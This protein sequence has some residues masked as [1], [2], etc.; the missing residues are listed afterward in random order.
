MQGFILIKFS[1]FINYYS[2]NSDIGPIQIQQAIPIS[3]NIT[4]VTY[5]SVV[6]NII[7]PIIIIDINRISN[8]FEFIIAMLLVNNKY[9]S[10]HGMS[11][12]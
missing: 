5:I 11:C 12:Y 6:S 3:I 2:I 4:L 1:L 9:N 10:L 8:L 7:P